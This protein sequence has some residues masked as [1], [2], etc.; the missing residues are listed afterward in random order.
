M[1]RIFGAACIV[2]FWGVVAEAQSKSRPEGPAITNPQPHAETA[3]VPAIVS[4]SP[5]S[6]SPG[7]LLTIHGTGFGYGWGNSYLSI[8]FASGSFGYTTWPTQSWNDTEI[9][10]TVPSTMPQGKVY[11]IVWANGQYSPGWEPFTV[12]IPP[13]I[14]AVAPR[15]GG[16]GTVVKITGSGFGQ[17]QNDSFVTVE[18]G[19]VPDP[20][21]AWPVLSWSDTEIDVPVPAD[22]PAREVFFQVVVNQLGSI[23]SYPYDVGTPPTI[24][25]FA[26][27]FGL[28]GSSLA[29]S[30]SGFGATQATSTVSLKSGLTDTVSI[31][32]VTSWS[33]SALAVTIPNDM[34]LGKVYLS[35]VAGGLPSIGTNAFTVGTP[36]SV[37]P[38]NGYWPTSGL[39]GTAITIEGSG[40][41]PTQGAS[42][43]RAQSPSQTF[44]LTITSWSD[45]RIVGTVPAIAPTGQTYLWVT[46][47]GVDTTTTCPFYV[48]TVPSINEINGY[49]PTFGPSGTAITIGGKGFGQTQGGSIVWALSQATGTIF[50]LTA[51][52]WSDTQVVV[53]VPSTAPAG[54]AYLGVKID[55][56][57]SIGTFPFTVGTPPSLDGYSLNSGR[58]GSTLTIIGSGFG[59]AQSGNR[60]A[61]QSQ[62]NTLMMLTIKSWTDGRIVAQIPSLAGSFCGYLYVWANGLESQGTRPFCIR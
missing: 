4:Y 12:G 36:P 30:G 24:L 58:A 51:A 50:N 13:S 35:V 59:R 5:T 54:P 27:P 52:N 15:F 22:T 16:P 11:L 60:V 17:S 26:P 53:T 55:G 28:P 2:L 7:T 19:A 57:K 1:K 43:V 34:P 29:I 47:N 10:T 41:G 14:S 18:W 8:E 45:T 61:I 49:S 48:G 38:I 42:T 32:P 25:G 33:D 31:L 46:A 40:F 37:N 23:G 21:S 6:G 62:S 44:N 3:T 9:V 56:V 39:P 20:G